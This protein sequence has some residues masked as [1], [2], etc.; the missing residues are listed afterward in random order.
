MLGSF[1][2]GQKCWEDKT[3]QKLI[4]YKRK[5]KWDLQGGPNSHN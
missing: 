5:G 1:Q 4:Y 2:Q 3:D